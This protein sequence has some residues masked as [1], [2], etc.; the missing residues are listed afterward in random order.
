[1]KHLKPLTL[2]LLHSQFS[3]EYPNLAC[4]FTWRGKEL[5]TEIAYILGQDRREAER[6]VLV[7]SICLN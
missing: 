5:F 4:L 7:N 1:M 6:F 3:A 2:E